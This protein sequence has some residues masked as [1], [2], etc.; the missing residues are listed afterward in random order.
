MNYS[1]REWLERSMLATA[2]SLAALPGSRSTVLAAEPAA[3]GGANETVRV[4]CIRG[5]E[6]YNSLAGNKKLNTVVSYICDVDEEVGKK[7]CDE[8]EKK[9]GFRPVYVNDMRKVFDDKNI[10]AITTAT[11][12][13]WH[14][15]CAI[16]ALQAGKH[17]YVEKPVSH[18]VSEGRRIVEAAR[19]YKL[20]CQTGTQS[21]SSAGM[22]EA[23]KYVHDGKLGNVKLARGLCYKPRG[24]IGERGNYEVPKAVNYDLWC[25][26]AP[27]AP[28]TRPKLH[29]DW[30]WQWDCGNGDLGNQGIH[31]MDLA[32]WALQV[33]ELSR[34]VLSYGGRFGY[35]DAGDTANTQVVIHDYGTKTL[36]FEVRG[37]KTSPFKGAGVG[38]IVE[39]SEGYLVMTSYSDGT[40]FDKSG[41]ALKQFMGGGDHFAN[42]INAVRQN[43][44][45]S[46]NADILEGHLSSGLC[47]TGNISLRLGQACGLSE[48]KERLTSLKVQDHVQDTLDRTVSHL[49]D[50]KVVLNDKLMFQVGNYLKFDPATETFPGNDAANAML[51][52]EYRAPFTV[53]SQDKV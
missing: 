22:R 41:A 4:A 51:T 6:H 32:R 15:L 16:W 35:T 23:M 25:G 48:L 28:L 9:Q 36:I 24:S 1:R 19:K 31:Q 53:P 42:F 33:N 3:P 10:D 13:H 2:A 30:H 27:V 52:R 17:V 14:A 38:L 8:I 26:P 20:V 11:P 43:D 40:V 45:T 49:A 47:H 50:N 7:A 5:K 29:Y 37:L 18:N 12:N 44:H 46:L 34:G 39:G 21:R